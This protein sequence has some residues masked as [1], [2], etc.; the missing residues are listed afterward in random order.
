MLFCCHQIKTA[1]FLVRFI[2][3]PTTIGAIAESSPALAQEITKF[4][5]KDDQRPVKILEVGPGT[6]VF[7]RFLLEKLRKDDKLDV[8]ELDGTFI[9]QLHDEFGEDERIRIFHD[10][11]L[12]FAYGQDYDFIVSGLPLNSFDKDLVKKITNRLVN[13]SKNGAIISFFEYEELAILRSKLTAFVQGSDAE[14][15]A[16]REVIVT[17]LS[18]FEFERGSVK[19]NTPSAV[20]HHL[21]ISK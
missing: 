9:G 12:E 5:P 20:V 14:F 7:T 4:F 21:L 1:D 11:I 8:V 13:L 2:K 3:N 10:D 15:L 18:A 6:G 16:T 17:F 19:D